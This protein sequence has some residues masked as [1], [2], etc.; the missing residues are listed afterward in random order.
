MYS[1]VCSHHI[2][3]EL[4]DVEVGLLLHVA[5]DAGLYQGATALHLQAR[6]GNAGQLETF[7]V[8]NAPR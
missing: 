2:K 6:G 3:D 8:T 5:D 7:E 4:I 1:T